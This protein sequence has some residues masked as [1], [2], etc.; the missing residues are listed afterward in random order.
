MCST[1]HWSQSHL[2]SPRPL[3]MVSDYDVGFLRLLLKSKNVVK[4]VKG[5]VSDISTL[6]ND[7]WE[8]REEWGKSSREIPF[9]VPLTSS[10][11]V[12]I[13]GLRQ[14]MN[15]VQSEVSW[16]GNENRGLTGRLVDF[17]PLGNKCLLWSSLI[18]FPHASCHLPYL[19]WVVRA[20]L[21]SVQITVLNR[22]SFFFRCPPFNPLPF[23][24][25]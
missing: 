20:P 10:I 5:W 19:G 4:V 8:S 12:A 13:G 15:L 1:I 18:S 24:W 16:E 17:L 21:G 14:V 6:Q 11:S 23:F 2:P 22:L 25:V 3:V 9:T 7:L